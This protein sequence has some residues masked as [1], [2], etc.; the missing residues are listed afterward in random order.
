MGLRVEPIQ[1]PQGLHALRGEWTALQPGHPFQSWEWV[2][3]WWQHL[4]ADSS[5]VRD[6]LYAWSVRDA[7]GALVA[8][9]P[10][11]RSLRPGMGPLKLRVVQ[12]F[13]MD[14]NITEVR[15]LPC[16]QGCERDALPA[17]LAHLRCRSGEWDWLDLGSIRCGS[18]AALLLAGEDGVEWFEHQP[19]Y[20]LPLAASWE[21][22]RSRL[23]RNIKESLRKCYNS[24]K[25][26]G[27]S[28]EL[29]VAR[30]P[31]EVAS[32]LPR[33]LELHA[34]RA[35]LT[36]TVRHRDVFAG[37]AAR[38]FLIDVCA[39]LAE[40]G[41]TRV[42]QLVIGDSVVASRI[43]FVEG[44][45]LYLYFSG[46][47]PAY[48]EYSVMTTT[49]CEAIQWAIREGFSEVDLS[50][51]SDVSKLRWAPEEVLWQSAL[52]RSPTWRGGVTRQAY[53]TATRLLGSELLRRLAGRRS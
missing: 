11:L 21:E 53:R 37:G 41:H 31:D 3:S 35:L 17:L 48:G 15:A 1:D 7:D 26:A 16:R 12:P 38:A 46:F 47:D 18:P 10:L 40:R 25:R 24:L 22:Q 33:F 50:F 36:G 49:V 20:L 29:R 27:L 6:E 13:G 23:S 52:V 5:L 8:V 45:R 19:E 32:S 30:T 42:F 43:G 4:R 2:T 44:D 9:A 28:W 51:G 39:S 34:A 14:A